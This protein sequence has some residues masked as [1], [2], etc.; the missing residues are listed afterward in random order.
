MK[1]SDLVSILSVVV[2]VSAAIA[3]PQLETVFPGH[4]AYL[5]AVLTVVGLAAAAI[6]RTLTNKTGAPPAGIAAGTPI[7]PAG[8]TVVTDATPQV[9]INSTHEP[10]VPPAAPPQGVS[11]P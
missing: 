4:G 11:A 10:I 8:T 1:A 5:S 3:G 6:I 9:A 2:A 7:V